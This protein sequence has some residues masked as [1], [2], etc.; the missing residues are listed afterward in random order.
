[1]APR[2]ALDASA[3]LCLLNDEP[4]ADRVEEVLDASL[5]SAVNYSETIAK[6]T[7]HGLDRE[8]INAMLNPLQLAIAEFDQA[9]AEQAG[10]LRAATRDAGLSFGDRACL[11]LAASRQLTVLTAD[12]AWAKIDIGLTIELVR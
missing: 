11:A 2:Y 12:R 9:Q 1:M 6:L 7:E 8:A 4:G 10:C 5:V 3:L